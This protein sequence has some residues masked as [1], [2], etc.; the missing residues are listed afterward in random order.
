M[1]KILSPTQPACISCCA[2][3]PPK[4]DRAAPYYKDIYHTHIMPR[5]IRSNDYLYVT[6]YAFF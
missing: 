2:H 4:R 5:A 3:A 6:V 1:P